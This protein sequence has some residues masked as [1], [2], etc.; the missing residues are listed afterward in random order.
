VS[1]L[2]TLLICLI[3]YHLLN[4]NS[5]SNKQ[6]IVNEKYNNYSLKLFDTTNSNNIRI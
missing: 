3:M 6:I 4:N 2:L 5:N 1:L